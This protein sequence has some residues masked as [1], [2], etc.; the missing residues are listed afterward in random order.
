MLALSCEPLDHQLVAIC[1]D[2]FVLMQDYSN[3]TTPVP[4]NP[5][6][7]FAPPKRLV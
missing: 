4:F 6:R 1:L 7:Q 5:F 3:V 2:Q